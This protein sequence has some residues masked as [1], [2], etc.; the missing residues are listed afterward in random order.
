M[1]FNEYLEEEILRKIIGL[2]LII[3]VAVLAIGSA[4]YRSDAPTASAKGRNQIQLDLVVS[5]EG[6][7]R[8]TDEAGPLTSMLGAI[9]L[10]L[11]DNNYQIDSFFDVYYV[12][13]IGDSGEDGVSFKAGANFDV[14][15]EVGFNLGRGGTFDTEIIAMSLSSSAPDISNPQGAIDIVRNAVAANKG[16]VHYGHVTVLK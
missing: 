4:L 16:R 15:F 2:T 9:E 12:S 6:I 11:S 10:A 7:I 14:F 13:N 1:E 5:V 8:A 3:M